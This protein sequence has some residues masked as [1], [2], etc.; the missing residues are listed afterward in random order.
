MLRRRKKSKQIS[1]GQLSELP[2]VLPS[3][4]G[5]ALLTCKP[6]VV[7]NL[8][9]MITRIIQTQDFPAKLS[10]LSTLR[11]EGVTYL[12]RAMSTV[13]SH[14]LAKSVCLIDLNWQYQSQPLVPDHSSPGMV[15]AVAGQATIDEILVRTGKPNLAWVPAGEID[16]SS[17]AHYR[18]K[19]R[20]EGS[21]SG[22]RTTI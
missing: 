13:M 3:E 12:S 5:E 6:H 15:A 14:D 2:L 8:R 10:L 9:R 4:D 22:A 7:D 20:F 17:R 16:A 11:G 1:T 19:R 21:H 18:P